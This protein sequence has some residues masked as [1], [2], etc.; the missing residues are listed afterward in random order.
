MPAAEVLEA[1]AEISSQ[2]TDDD[3]CIV[4]RIIDLL[5]VVGFR[6]GEV[7]TLPRDCWVGNGP[8]STGSRYQGH[9][10]G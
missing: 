6:V 8:L 5:A 7:L 4:L 2:A 1:L 10:N 3:E 9:H